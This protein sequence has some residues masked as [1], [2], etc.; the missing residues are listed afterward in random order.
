MARA[1]TLLA[2]MLIFL[3]LITT[4]RASELKSDET[5]VFLSG[6]GSFESNGCRIDI[7]GW[8]YESEYHKPVTSLLRRALGIRDD[9]LTA[10]ELATF[11]QR[12]QFFL[13]DNERHK[14]VAVRLGDMTLE[15]SPS[16]PN[17]HF[18][19]SFHLPT[20]DLTRAGLSPTNF[21]LPFRTVGG[22]KGFHATTGELRFIPTNGISVI[23]DV[24]D[25]IK[26]SAVNSRHELLRNTFCRPYQAV[27]GMAEAYERWAKS[28][29]VT[30]HYV[31]ASPWQLYVPLEAFVRSN[32]FPAGTLNLKAFR[33]KDRT[34]FDLFKS[35]E[36]YKLSTIEP[37]MK[38][39][40]ERRLVLV[41]D[42]GEKDPEIYGTIARKHTNQIA[43]IFIRNVTAEK[44]DSARYRSA[45]GGLSTNLWH[46][47]TSPSELPA[48]LR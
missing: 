16:L 28:D 6:I 23:S 31:S 45:F 30:F 36:E 21:V 12:A 14:R 42:S 24:D 7:R 35:P 9:E 38:R 11:R 41:G 25:T 2:S 34:F 43:Q 37:L 3:L 1:G 47:F 48:E 33:W 8:V 39:F 4:S 29:G 10:A 27:P 32:G 44:A 13:V 20:I 22:S 19:S 17:G 18:E 46:V 40:P 15:L 26:I 5:L